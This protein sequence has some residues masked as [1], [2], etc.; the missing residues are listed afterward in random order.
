VESRDPGLA[1]SHEHTQTAT[2]YQT[3]INNKDW[4]L[5]QMIF[6]I[7]REKPNKRQERCTVIQSNPIPPGERLTSHKYLGGNNIL[8]EKNLWLSHKTH[9]H[10][11]ILLS[12]WADVHFQLFYNKQ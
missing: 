3:I 6:Y 5:P 1:S 4:S 12:V 10:L 2:N 11:V 8:R 7:Q 9:F